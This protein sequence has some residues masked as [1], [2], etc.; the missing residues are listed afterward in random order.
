[1]RDIQGG[2]TEFRDE[3]NN[4]IRKK[5]KPFPFKAYVQNAKEIKVVTPILSWSE[6]GND[7]YLISR[8][9]G[10]SCDDLVA[11]ID[12]AR[13]KFVER[14]GGTRKYNKAVRHYILQFQGDV[15]LDGKC[16]KSS[17][18]KKDGEL[19]IEGLPVAADITTDN[20][21]TYD[22]R[23]FTKNKDGNMEKTEVI[24]WKQAVV[25]RLYWE[26][27]DRA[28]DSK[29]RG[30]TQQEDSSSDDEDAGVK[31]MARKMGSSMNIS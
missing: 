13:N 10:K 29:K 26:V 25:P 4:I 2:Y 5:V 21:G 9:W 31:A 24:L 15:R 28:Q 14:H 12:D 3:G 17:K 16:L 1:M 23:E 20:D 7:D 11:G 27:A 22:K 6:K 8:E 30:A 18:K 19:Q